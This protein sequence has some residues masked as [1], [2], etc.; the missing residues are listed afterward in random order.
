VVKPLDFHEFIDAI[1]ALGA[2]WAV[3]NEPPPQAA[4]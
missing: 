2:F 3:L 4:S 1:R